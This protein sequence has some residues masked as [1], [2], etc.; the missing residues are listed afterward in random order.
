MQVLKI[1]FTVLVVLSIGINLFAYIAEKVVKRKIQ[2]KA[3]E[4]QKN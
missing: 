3:K 2:K 4:L 1:I